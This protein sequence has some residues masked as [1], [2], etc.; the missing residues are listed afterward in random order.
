MNAR[1]DIV[2]MADTGAL[3][4]LIHGCNCQSVMGAGLAR[5][6]REKWWEVF[7]ADVQFSVTHT[8]SEKLGR[9]SEAIIPPNKLTMGN[10]PLTIINAYTQLDFG[11]SGK[12]YLSY[13]AVD[14]AFS[15]FT[16][17]YSTEL[18]SPEC[19]VGI[20]RIGG[21]LGGANWS[22]V[23]TIIE[24]NFKGLAATLIFVDYALED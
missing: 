24:E 23:R 6:L 16:S 3:D 7:Q 14:E 22:I 2:V 8:P 17:Y 18:D 21:G 10:Y 13:D 9:Y 5:A 12:R 19:R 15:A 11:R 1:G 20:P 4:F